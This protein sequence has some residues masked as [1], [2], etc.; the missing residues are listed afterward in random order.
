MIYKLNEYIYKKQNGYTFKGQLFLKDNIILIYCFIA[1]KGCAVD[2]LLQSFYSGFKKDEKDKAIND[3]L[4]G[5][6]KVSN[7][8]YSKL[9]NNAKELIEIT[10]CNIGN[11]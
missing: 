9:N 4:S 5:K 3:Y 10:N 11:K 1:V 7:N 6:I 8:D 2:C